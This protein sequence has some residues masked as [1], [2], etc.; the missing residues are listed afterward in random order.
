M[1]PIITSLLCTFFTL[2]IRNWKAALT[3]FSIQFEE[4]M[5]QP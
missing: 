3:Q 2:P 4:R 1:V 5:P